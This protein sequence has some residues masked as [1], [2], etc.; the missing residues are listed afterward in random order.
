MIVVAA[1]ASAGNGAR[2]TGRG[3]GVDDGRGCRTAGG[4]GCCDVAKG[5]VKTTSATG[6]SGT[7]TGSDKEL[8]DCSF[9]S[10]CCGGAGVLSKV[11]NPCSA[12][13]LECSLR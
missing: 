5:E 3:G 4:C 13:A 12:P 7:V 11:S 1:D 10:R 6:E 2:S 8:R 9:C